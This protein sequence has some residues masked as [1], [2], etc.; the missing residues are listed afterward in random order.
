MQSWTWA[1]KAWPV[2]AIILL[3]P[4]VP[5]RA[6]TGP[7]YDA[8][9]GKIA[10]DYSGNATWAYEKMDRLCGDA[11][12]TEAPAQ[13]FNKVMHSGIDWGGG[14]QWQWENAIDLCER[15]TNAEVTVAC[16]QAKVSS[17]APWDQAIAACDERAAVTASGTP[18]PG[19]PA[20]GAWTKCAD[21]N[22]AC[23]FAGTREVRY[24]ANGAYATGVF[25]GS[26]A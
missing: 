12:Y 20:G 5:A 17:G 6:D 21:E 15:T 22:G 25:T 9:Q 16:F 14:T 10:W 8:L 1:R 19:T 7:C 24:G 4:S 26:V 13:C 3:V 18:A 11:H 2:A 23:T